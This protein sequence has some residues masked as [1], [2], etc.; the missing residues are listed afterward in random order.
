MSDEIIFL[1]EE[2]SEGGYEAKALGHSIFTEG[3]DMEGLRAAVVDAVKCHFEEAAG[4]TRKL[5]LLLFAIAILLSGCLRQASRVSK[6][7]PLV[8]KYT[9]ANAKL[10]ISQ[11]RESRSV[12]AVKV[13]VLSYGKEPL[14][15]MPGAYSR[16]RVRV[17]LTKKHYLRQEYALSYPDKT[18]EAKL[19][20]IPATGNQPRALLKRA[21]LI[22]GMPMAYPSYLPKGFSFK[23]AKLQ[24]QAPNGWGVRYFSGNPE[25]TALW[26]KGR[27]QITMKFPPESQWDNNQTAE[28]QRVGFVKVRVSDTIEGGFFRGSI[29]TPSFQADGVD[30]PWRLQLKGVSQGETLKVIKGV[31]LLYDPS[32]SSTPPYWQ[33]VDTGFFTLYLPPGWKFTRLRGI[34]S[35]VGEFSGPDMKLTF[36][37]GAYTGDFSGS[38]ERENYVITYRNV[39]GHRAEVATS[40]A[41]VGLAGIF[42]RDLG[43]GFIGNDLGVYG[44][45]L[46]RGK[47]ALAL[48]I[49]GTIRE[50]R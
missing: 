32:K 5:Y 34:D 31:R 48:K 43:K 49:F 33:F 19:M 10:R 12:I 9:P 30:V 27:Q 36:D 3:D 18:F 14:K 8:V 2:S 4:Y 29:D 20:R 42:I 24:A 39:G 22:Y 28:P 17:M 35:F 50:K 45:N 47:Q 25:I 44:Q 26:T 21:Q 23:G 38:S 37:Y 15:G 6:E 13:K 7:G 46:S 11:Q 1:V 41:D 16:N 40:K